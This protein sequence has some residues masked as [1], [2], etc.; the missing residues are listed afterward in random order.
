MCVRDGR[1]VNRGPVGLRLSA[2]YSL[3]IEPFIP[4]HF[5]NTD[6]YTGLQLNT[7]QQVESGVLLLIWNENLQLLWRSENEDQT[8][9]CKT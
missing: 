6:I 7:F 9:N 2:V 5:T 8:R 1:L 4:N 3:S